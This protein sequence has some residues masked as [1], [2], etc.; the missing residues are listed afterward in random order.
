M[1]LESS[2]LPRRAFRDAAAVPLAPSGPEL[3]ALIAVARRAGAGVGHAALAWDARIEASLRAVHAYLVRRALGEKWA[4][5]H[6]SGRYGCSLEQLA[7]GLAPIMGWDLPPKATPARRRFL[8]RHRESVRRWLDWL[9][10]AGLV[11]HTPQCDGRGRWWRTVIELHAVPTV[12]R[13]LLASS[14]SRAI[15]ALSA[16][17]RLRLRSNSRISWRAR[18]RRFHRASMR[19]ECSHD[20]EG[21][22]TQSPYGENSSRRPG[23]V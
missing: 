19:N 17:A 16:S 9:Q 11:S 3:V 2:T 21:H 1:A 10:L 13:E 23:L 15:A 4:G 14:V 6:G 12:D 5:P 22:Q 7:A 8:R 18:W 20:R